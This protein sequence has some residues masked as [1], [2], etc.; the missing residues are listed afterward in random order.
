MHIIISANKAKSM[1]VVGGVL[2]LRPKLNMEFK[3]PAKI[4]ALT[5]LFEVVCCGLIFLQ[6]FQ[7]F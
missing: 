6:S 2:N 1:H 3:I 4:Y 5:N 7:I